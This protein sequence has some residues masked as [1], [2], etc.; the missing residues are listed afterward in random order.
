MALRALGP[1]TQAIVQAVDAALNSHDRAIMVACS[2]GADSLALAGASGR[3][4]RH[5]GLDV[6]AVVVDH[7][8]QAGS[9][10]VAAD[11]RCQ[12]I[13]LGV[14][15]CIVVAVEVDPSAGPGP[16]ASARQARYRAL[17]AEAERR[18]ATVLLGHTLDDQAETVLLGLARGSGTRSLAGMAVRTGCYLRPMLSLSRKTTEAAC[19]ELGVVP[20]QDPHN[21]EPRFT[22]SRVRS[23]V[24]PVLEAELGPGVAESLARTARM[25]RDDADLLDQLAAE[26]HPITTTLDCATLYSA[27]AALRRRVIRRWLIDRGAAEATYRQVVAVETL[28]T[29]WRGQRG[30]DVAGVQV[31]RRVG[32]LT[33]SA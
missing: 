28:I 22:R 14:P 8:L 11:A 1:A 19:A 25:A 17:A 18:Q 12:L 27:P 20:W 2:G 3:L 21:A 4:I 16:E 10:A 24:L 31:S 15:D 26:L 32:R 23:R 13:R 30:V 6:S 5:R 29:D 7:G 33:C 9:A